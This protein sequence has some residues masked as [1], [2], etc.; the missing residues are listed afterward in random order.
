MKTIVVTSHCKRLKTDSPKPQSEDSP[1]CIRAQG[2]S[3]L[4]ELASRD[5]RFGVFE[6]GELQGPSLA[7]AI[8]GGMCFAL[9]GGASFSFGES[10]T[11]S[12]TLWSSSHD[13]G[14]DIE[15]ASYPMGSQ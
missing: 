9:R 4:V 10:K 8:G 1:S 12:G 15:D 13:M 2:D 7:S 5:G 6:S 14:E 3:T 11:K